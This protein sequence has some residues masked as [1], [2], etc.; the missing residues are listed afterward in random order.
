M[1]SHWSNVDSTVMQQVKWSL[2]LLCTSQWAFGAKITSYRRQS[3]VMTSHR[4]SFDVILRLCPLGFIKVSLSSKRLMILKIWNWSHKKLNLNF[5][6]FLPNSESPS[7]KRASCDY[8]IQIGKQVSTTCYEII[9]TS[10]ILNWNT[11]SMLV[12]L[13]IQNIVFISVQRYGVEMSDSHSI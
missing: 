6:K 10:L 3:D 1:S 12:W 9:T 7:T 11:F 13:R 2:S 5:C 8:R 4:G